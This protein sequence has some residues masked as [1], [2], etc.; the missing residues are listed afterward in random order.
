MVLWK[1]TIDNSVNYIARSEQ[2]KGKDIKLDK[3]KNN[4]LPR[5]QNKNI[6]QNNKVF[7]KDFA[8]QRFRL[9]KLLLIK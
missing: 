9:L 3:I 4:L 6:S 8:A 5:K 2:T 1:I 7:I